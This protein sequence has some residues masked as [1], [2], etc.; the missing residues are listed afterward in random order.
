MPYTPR[1]LAELFHLVF[2]RALVG[3]GED[4]AR[5]A[6]KGGCNLR[7]YFE[8]VRYSEDIDFDV[9]GIPKDTLKNKVERLLRS[10]LIVSPLKSK[11]IAIS[12]VTAP[13][14]T[15]TTQRWK[16][17]L[18]AT[19]SSVP[20]RTKVE[21]SR[22]NAIQGAAFASIGG[23]LL[24]PYALP[25]FLATHYTAHGAVSQKIHALAERAEPQARDVFDLNL[26]FARP[27]AASL[28][29]LQAEKRW[30]G[31]AIDHTLDI[32]F[33]EY[34]SKVVAYLDPSQLDVYAGRPAWD[35]MQG[36]VI[37]S[38]EALR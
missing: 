21:F 33:D 3:K 19:G 9:A 2:L 29:L 4:K 37:S 34:R 35:A 7:F 18:V 28:V 36:S 20:L 14:Q 8:S 23:D 15:E 22:R 5:I 13:K 25:P 31:P 6:L 1:Q 16:L 24:R 30:L 17:G 26:L 27:E 12:E 10:P 38:L 11:G 32:S